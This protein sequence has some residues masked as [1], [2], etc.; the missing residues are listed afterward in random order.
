MEKKC[1]QNVPLFQETIILRDEAARLLGYRN[2]AAFRIEDKMA[3]NPATVQ[4]FLGDLREKLAAGGA[5][6]I[7]HLKKIKVEDLRSRGLENTYDG[8]FYLW[9]S[10]FYNRMM[11]E[12]EFS[13]DEQ[14][15]SQ[16][17]P[18]QSTIEGM[19][20]IFEELF[21][22]QFVEVIGEDRDKIS[23]SK[24]SNYYFIQS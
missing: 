22:F 17:F 24:S 1:N 5:K 3:K 2:H 12:K 23:S 19:L 18:L 11:I 16:Y 14:E 21:G 20:R 6:E 13:I 15:I 4:N 10:R 9:D 8:N 7:K